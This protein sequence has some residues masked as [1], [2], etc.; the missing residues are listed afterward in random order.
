MGSCLV[1]PPSTKAVQRTP[2]DIAADW[3]LELLLR[4]DESSSRNEDPNED[5]IIILKQEVIGL[6]ITALQQDTRVQ[7][8]VF[9]EILDIVEP[10]TSYLEYF[11]AK[12]EF[13]HYI[14]RV[15]HHISLH[16]ERLF[17]LH[18]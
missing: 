16:K 12:D 13:H 6:F 10:Y 8:Q 15:A 17:D 4:I 9:T 5:D 18:I 2:K 1:S 7:W 14:E 3:C 11:D